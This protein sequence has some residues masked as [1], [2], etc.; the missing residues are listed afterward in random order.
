MELNEKLFKEYKVAKGK[1]L[2]P[3]PVSPYDVLT[4]AEYN[5]FADR[6]QKFDYYIRSKFPEKI[7]KASKLLKD[8]GFKATPINKNG[9]FYLYFNETVDIPKTDYRPSY[10]IRE[11]LD[12]K[13]TIDIDFID[14]D[15][16][17]WKILDQFGLEIV[18]KRIDSIDVKG[19]KNNLVKYLMS[20]YYGMDL[21]DIREF[22]PILLE[23]KK[24]KKLNENRNYK[25][26]TDGKL[27]EVE[28]DGYDGTWYEIDKMLVNGKF[29]YLMEHEEYG[30]ETTGLV[31]SHDQSEIYETFDDIETTLRDNG[32]L[33]QTTSELR[34]PYKINESL[35]ELTETGLSFVISNLIKDELD[36]VEDYTSLITTLKE[37]GADEFIEIVEHIREEE[38]KHVGHLQAILEKLSPSAKSIEIGKSEAE[39]SLENVDSELSI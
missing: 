35:D 36:A 25:T 2:E 12:N 32:V 33:I 8:A 10:L 39:L 19:T 34:K 9:R 4:A 28:I 14:E 22:F 5:V 1:T 11:E 18:N 23:S 31:I 21:E 20:D 6:D 17:A 38:N 24:S 13:I 15:G 26:T 37:F 7:K 16:D 30:D 27:E 3:K 29:Y